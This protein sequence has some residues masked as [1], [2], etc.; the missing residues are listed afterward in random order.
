M[1]A[2][3]I[4]FSASSN[5]AIVSGAVLFESHIHAL[6]FWGGGRRCRGTNK[7]M[8]AHIYTPCA[9]M[10]GDKANRRCVLYSPGLQVLAT[11]HSQ[12][13]QW[14]SG[15]CALCSGDRGAQANCH[16]VIM[17]VR[18]IKLK[19]SADHMQALH[20]ALPPKQVPCR[21]KSRQRC[22]AK[23]LLPI[24]AASFH[25]PFYPRAT[26]FV[27]CLMSVG[28][29]QLSHESRVWDNFLF[30][31]APCQAFPSHTPTS[32]EDSSAKFALYV[33]FH[34]GFLLGPRVGSMHSHRGINSPSAG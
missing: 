22:P 6:H 7:S 29:C 2:L 28:V 13:G 19:G 8:P 21:P 32:L 1:P 30:L 14:P 17:H 5:R 23:P 15:K 33:T 20:D 27:G 4:S 26:A 10:P 12:A 34:F 11:V 18:S 16:I 9:Q 25:F 3:Y 31:V 24:S